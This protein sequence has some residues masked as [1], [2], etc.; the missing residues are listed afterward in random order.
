[1]I[2][3]NGERAFIYY[4]LV[5]GFEIFFLILFFLNKK[6]VESFFAEKLSEGGKGPLYIYN[7]ENQKILC[8]IVKTMYKKKFVLFKKIIRLFC[9][10]IYIFSVDN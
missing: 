2:L 1:M 3:R 10:T 9:A 5:N 6:K 8:I 4:L 7:Q